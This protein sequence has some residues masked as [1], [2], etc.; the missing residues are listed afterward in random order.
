MMLQHTRCWTRALMLFLL[1]W[2]AIL[3]YLLGP[4]WKSSE[5]EE[6][7]SRQLVEA[8]GELVR[9]SAENIEQ[10]KLLK[11]MQDKLDKHQSHHANNNDDNDNDPMVDNAL[12]KIENDKT[13]HEFSQVNSK[14]MSPPA[15]E[16]SKEYELNRRKIFRD[17][18]ELWWYVRGKL[19]E[20]GQ[21]SNKD[22]VS[23]LL[24]R[25]IVETQHRHGSL[26]A[27]LYQLAEV[28]GWK[29]WREQEAKN[30]SDLVQRRLH[31]L[32]NPKDC[33]TA[34]KLV[35]KLNKGKCHHNIL[36]YNYVLNRAILMLFY[37]LKVAGMDVKFI[38]PFIAS[39]SLMAQ[40]ER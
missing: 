16:P 13:K 28:D 12:E 21:K 24:N 26:L 1:V 8:N 39:L 27:D 9:L 3:V 30:L 19:E 14:G 29:G 40:K 35:C 11:N 31:A 33:S 6:M 38:M 7:M 10:R 32:Q 34:K 15:N 18:N 20:M 37:Y 2:F 36:I 25:T 5:N 23:E 17:L 4:L 22:K